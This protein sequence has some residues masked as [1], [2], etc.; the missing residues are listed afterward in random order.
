MI[1]VLII[2]LVI[3]YAIFYIITNKIHIN[4]DTFFRRG[5]KK[6]DNTFG[7]YCYVGKQRKR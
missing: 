7:L 2:A 6:L 5:F 3:G 1:F 4:W